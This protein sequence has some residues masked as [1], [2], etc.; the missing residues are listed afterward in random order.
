V[1]SLGADEVVAATTLAVLWNAGTIA[2]QPDQPSASAALSTLL[3][4]PFEQLGSRRPELDAS[5]VSHGIVGRLSE[6]LWHGERPSAAEVDHLV[7]FA[8]SSTRAR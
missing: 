3:R 4:E 7:A 8:L 2:G 5:L 6:L 1:L